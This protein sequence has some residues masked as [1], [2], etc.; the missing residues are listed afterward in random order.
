MFFILVKINQSYSR[1]FRMVLCGGKTFYKG[2]TTAATT[3]IENCRFLQKY[4]TGS[5]YYLKELWNS[6]RPDCF[7]SFYPIQHFFPLQLWH[8]S[9]LFL[10]SRYTLFSR[11]TYEIE[12][13]KHKWN[14]QWALGH[15]FFVE[16]NKPS[17]SNIHPKESIESVYFWNSAFIT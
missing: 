17:N 9:K 12:M 7:S 1:R 3:E 6:C 11:D 15:F 5:K 4:L 2:I 10:L 8:F 14:V 13:K 16:Q